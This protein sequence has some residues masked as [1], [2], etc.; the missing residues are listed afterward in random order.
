MTRFVLAILLGLLAQPLAAANLR[1]E[2][3]YIWSAPTEGFGGFSGLEVTADG[4][5]FTT[6]SDRGKILTGQFQRQDGKI[7]GVTVLQFVPLLNRKSKPVHRYNTDAEGLAVGPQGRIFVSFEGNHRV[8]RYKSPISAAT[9]VRP[10]PDFKHFQ[11]NSGMEAL[12][13]DSNGTL[14]TMPERS[15]EIN[16]PFPVYRYLGAKWIKGLSI[17]RRG[18]FLAV[19]ADFGPDGKFY[20]LERDFIWYRGFATRIRRFELTDAGFSNEETLLT[21]DFGT[22]DNLEGIATWL[23]SAGRIRLTMVSDDNFNFLQT[24]EFV[25]YSLP[26][27]SMPRLGN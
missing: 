3:K 27:A 7:S 19:G 15:G 10:H 12:A 21:T 9:R 24:T 14:Y 1:F 6:I 8:W 25:E 17:P 13:V 26:A 11:N 2:D 5:N 18:R 16:R 22:Y 20:L 4:R 23:D